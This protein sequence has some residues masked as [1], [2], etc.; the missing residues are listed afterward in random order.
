MLTNFVRKMKRLII[1]GACVALIFAGGISA[2]RQFGWIFFRYHD[3]AC[4]QRGSVLASRYE[5]LKRDAHTKLRIGTPREDVVRFFKEE[6]LP[7]S[8]LRDEYA[9]T[10]YLNGC[11]PPGCGSDAALIGLRVK[12]DGDG[13]VA[14]EPD[15]G[16]IYTDC[17]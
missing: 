12:V 14:G 7:I 1:V 2:Y 4:R 8:F 5:T 3:A 10:I 16:S 13:A 6:G 15:I 9:G 11:A 17:L